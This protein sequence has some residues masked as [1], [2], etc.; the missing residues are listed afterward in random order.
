[1]N[2]KEEYWI[3]MSDKQKQMRASLE[4]YKM[5]DNFVNK[6]FEWLVLFFPRTVVKVRVKVMC[7]LVH[8]LRLCTGRTAHRGSRGIALL[9]HD[10]GTRRG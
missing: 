4:R 5:C 3:L 7:T 8:A 6:T 2:H 9:F 1:M 10:H